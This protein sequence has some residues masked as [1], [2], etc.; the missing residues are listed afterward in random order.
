MTINE[1]RDEL[2]KL[3]AWV[4]GDGASPVTVNGFSLE[5][6]GKI[7]GGCAA[8][9]TGE[10]VAC[11][12]EDKVARILEEAEEDANAIRNNARD[13]ARAKLE[14]LRCELQEI[15]NEL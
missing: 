4:G 9:T 6:C 2:D 3:Q 1:L 7:E 13:D 14:N 15:K 11:W 5:P 12:T 10:P 8:F